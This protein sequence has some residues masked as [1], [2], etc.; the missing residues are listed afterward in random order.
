[1]LPGKYGTL[2]HPQLHRNDDVRIPYLKFHNKTNFAPLLQGGRYYGA[3]GDPW[4]IY[5]ADQRLDFEL[6][7]KGARVRVYAEAGAE[8]FGDPPPPPPTIPR[9]FHYDR[10]FFVFLWRDKAEWPYFGA[11]IGNAAAMEKFIRQ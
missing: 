2:E 10:P 5:H 11:W 6:T 9:K 3:E 8:P 7:E 1:M 4:R